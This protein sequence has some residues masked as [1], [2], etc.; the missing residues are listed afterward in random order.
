[1]DEHGGQFLE[2]FDEFYGFPHVKVG[3]VHWVLDLKG[4][5][6]RSWIL[7]EK[8][9]EPDNTKPRALTNGECSGPR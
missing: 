5:K 4:E 9:L 3:S 8:R 6:I 2:L 1:V 7:T